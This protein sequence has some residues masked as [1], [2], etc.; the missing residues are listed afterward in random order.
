MRYAQRAAYCRGGRYGSEER[1]YTPIRFR[2]WNPTFVERYV[3][4]S[5]SAYD[6]PL[7]I[8]SQETS[9]RLLQLVRELAT[10]DRPSV[11]G[12]SGHDETRKGAPACR[13][14][15]TCRRGRMVLG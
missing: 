5:V 2:I 1:R 14:P 11:E 6:G 3:M 7:A 4:K 13:G 9:A 12:G 15:R 8:G 10:L